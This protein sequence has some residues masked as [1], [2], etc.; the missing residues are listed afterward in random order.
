[1]NLRE[2]LSVSLVEF[3]DTQLMFEVVNG[4]P[5]IFGKDAKGHILQLETQL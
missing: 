5:R 1:M 4:R 2:L 3:I